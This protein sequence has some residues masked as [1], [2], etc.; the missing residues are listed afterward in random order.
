MYQSSDKISNAL[1]ELNRTRDIS[2]DLGIFDE[3]HKTAVK[4]SGNQTGSPFQIALYNKNINMKRRLFL[5]ATTSVKKAKNVDQKDSADKHMAKAAID[6][7]NVEIYGKRVYALKLRKAI[8]KHLICDYQLL[9]MCLKGSE[10][11][12]EHVAHL[13]GVDTNIKLDVKNLAICIE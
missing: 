9:V 1:K 8:T 7:N 10:W 3:A 12:W 2:I 11:K 6:M 13:R 4:K 5:T